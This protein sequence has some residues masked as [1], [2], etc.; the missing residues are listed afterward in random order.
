[1]LNCSG[2]KKTFYCSHK[3]QKANWKEHKKLCKYKKKRIT[4]DDVISSE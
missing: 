3:C 2:C 4:T 1:M